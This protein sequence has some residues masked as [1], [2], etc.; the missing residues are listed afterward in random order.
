ME[1]KNYSV[2]KFYASTTDSVGVKL[3][4]EHIVYLAKEIGIAGVTVYRGVMGYGLSSSH[5]SSTKFWEFTEKL[6]V[7]IEMIDET[8][9]LEEFYKLVEPELE[10][11]QKGCLVYMLPVQIKLLKKGNNN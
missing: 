10:S 11:M 1:N 2:L 3:F 8:Q 4:Y 6:P 5:I 7:V 9:K